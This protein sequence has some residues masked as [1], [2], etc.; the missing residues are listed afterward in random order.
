MLTTG[1]VARGPE[2]NILNYYR[3]QIYLI[4]FSEY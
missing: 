3:Y 4:V 1:F 2:I